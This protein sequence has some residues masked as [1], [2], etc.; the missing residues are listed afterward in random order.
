MAAQRD[1]CRT[2]HRAENP[3]ERQAGI[4]GPQTKAER[5]QIGQGMS[6]ELLCAHQVVSSLLAIVRSLAKRKRKI[7]MARP[8]ASHPASMRALIVA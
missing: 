8:H 3:G 7:G 4:L 6:D 2:D 5:K 1:Y